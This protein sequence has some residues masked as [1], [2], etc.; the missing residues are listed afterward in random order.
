[1]YLA[2]NKKLIVDIA[3]MR[4]I[5][6]VTICEDAINSYGRVVYPFA[7]LH[8]QYFGLE[9]SYLLVLFRII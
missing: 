2:L 6:I 9:V 8:A 4:K 1:M 5:L 3:N 7:S